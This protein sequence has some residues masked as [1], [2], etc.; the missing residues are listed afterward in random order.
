VRRRRVIVRF[1]AGPA[2]GDGPPEA[3]PD[4]DAHERFIDDL[5]HRGAVV[6]GG[7]YADYTG[8]MVLLEGMSVEEVDR[9]VAADPFVQNGVFVLDDLREWVVYVDELSGRT[10][11]AS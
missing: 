1:A 5:V 4:W 3:Q 2:W 10:P 6:M 11:P 7:P 9:I 8:S